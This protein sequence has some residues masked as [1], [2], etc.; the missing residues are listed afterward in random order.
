MKPDSKI[1]EINDKIVTVLTRVGRFSF[2]GHAII[3]LVV[4]DDI[5]RQGQEDS[6]LF[7]SFPECGCKGSQIHSNLHGTSRH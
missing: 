1:R 5:S 2:I 3:A 4:M 7:F 6:I